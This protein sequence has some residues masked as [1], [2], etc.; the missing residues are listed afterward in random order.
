LPLLVFQSERRKRCSRTS[1][2]LPS[3]TWKGCRCIRDRNQRVSSKEAAADLMRKG[4]AKQE[5]DSECQ[6]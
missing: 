3:H 4:K 1:F 5:A 2:D 6:S